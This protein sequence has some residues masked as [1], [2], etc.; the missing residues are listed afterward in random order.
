MPT[1]DEPKLFIKKTNNYR[2]VYDTK[3]KKD[4]WD[5]K[6]CIYNQM[7]DDNSN[8]TKLNHVFFLI[9]IVD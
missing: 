5:S 8:P 9:Q 1:T 4:I 2:K 6:Y 3:M 7:G